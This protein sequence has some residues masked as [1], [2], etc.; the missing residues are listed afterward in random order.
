M[1]N[2][3]LKQIQQS[4]FGS[5]AEQN[6][7]LE[8]KNWAE[9]ND[10]RLQEKNVLMQMLKYP[11]HAFNDYRFERMNKQSP[12]VLSESQRLKSAMESVYADGAV[13]PDEAKL[14]EV[15]RWKAL[16]RGEGF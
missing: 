4:A 11:Y 16:M 10:S 8:A 9:R 15:M 7:K 3:K 13:S 5:T 12:D 2:E 1:G 14:S 6:A